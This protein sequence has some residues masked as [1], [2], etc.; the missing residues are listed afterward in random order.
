MLASRPSSPPA[1][2]RRGPSRVMTSWWTRD[3]RSANGSVG[4]GARSGSACCS[5]VT[6]TT[7]SG[8]RDWMRSERL[9]SRRLLVPRLGEPGHARLQDALAAGG[10]LLCGALLLRCLALAVRG[11]HR[12]ACLGTCHGRQEELGELAH[13]LRGGRARG[14]DGDRDAAVDGRADLLVARDHGRER[15]VERARDVALA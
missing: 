10:C 8:L 9:N 4:A 11:L 12:G 5:R 3:L 15:H 13:G 6:G 7:G 2:K 1:A 14:G